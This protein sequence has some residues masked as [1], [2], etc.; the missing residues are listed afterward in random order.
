MVN[1][2]LQGQNRKSQDSTRASQVEWGRRSGQLKYGPLLVEC[3]LSP[4][5]ATTMRVAFGTHR[6]Q[7]FRLASLGGRRR[8]YGLR[9][10]GIQEPASIGAVITRGDVPCAVNISQAFDFSQPPRPALLFD[11]HP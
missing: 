10:R 4:E 3:M 7:Q 2:G 5:A 9:W 11:T 6:S 1:S 8:R